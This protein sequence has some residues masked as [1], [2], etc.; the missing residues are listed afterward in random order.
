MGFNNQGVDALLTVELGGW[1]PVIATGGNLHGGNALAWLRA[2]ASP[3]Q[4]STGLGWGGWGK[5]G[6]RCGK[7]R[8]KP[9]RTGHT[10]QCSGP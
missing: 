1:L 5:S 4:L 3:V 7:S 9:I 8:G 6:K 2:G 10:S